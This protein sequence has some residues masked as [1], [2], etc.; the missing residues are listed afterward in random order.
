MQK[1]K[2]IAC[3]SGIL[4]IFILLTAISI[5]KL[6]CA[7]QEYSQQLVKLPYPFDFSTTSNPNPSTVGFDGTFPEVPSEMMVYKV[8]HPNNI[9][10]SY[11]R[12]LAQKHFGMPPDA[13]FEKKTVSY[14]L[15]SSTHRFWFEPQTG[16][17]TFEKI[18]R[19]DTRSVTKNE[20]P[21]K[22][23]CTIIAEKYLKDHDMY[24]DD[25]YI[26]GFA[27]NT[28]G[29]GYMSVGF[30]QNISG[31]KKFGAGGKMLFDI[32]PG[33]EV[34]YFRKAWKELV[35]YK[36]YPLKTARQA[37][38]DLHNRRGFLRG[39][40]GKIKSITIRYYT[41]PGKQEYI[42]PTY[43]FECSGP[44]GDF[45]GCVSAIKDKFIQSRKEYMKEM[46]KKREEA[47]KN[48]K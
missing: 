15:K 13:H 31:H 34:V 2:I 32:G 40:K 30:G 25:A 39:R 47:M 35:P 11:V 28:Q 42:Q 37:L 12:E 19:I 41:S 17:F 5:S 7:S 24:E 36:P 14:L 9:N 6:E 8:I 4:L 16:F 33:G 18:E 45:Y 10:E 20:Y 1:K 26:S 43:Y 46:D 29:G 23:D 38:R 27:D 22:K 48:G 3:V 21:V 44:D